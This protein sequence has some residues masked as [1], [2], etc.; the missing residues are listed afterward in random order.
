MTVIIAGERSGVGKTTI[1]LAI[2]AYLKSQNQSLQ[3]F[4]VGPDYID[5]MF[6]STITDKPCRNLD[7]I[8]TSQEYVKWCFDY[9]TQS[10]ELV[11]IEGV[12]GLF[13]GVPTDDSPYY[14]S[15]AYIAK[16][17]NLPVILIL[18]CSK[19]SMSVGAIALG[20]ITLDPNIQ[21]VGLILN[22]VGSKKHLTL[23]KA[24]LKNCGIPIIGVWFRQQE[25]KLPSRHLGLIPTEEIKEHQIIFQQLAQLAQENINW[26]LLF[27][28]LVH[29]SEKKVDYFFQPSQEYKLKIAIARDKSLNFYYQDNLDILEKF[30]VELVFFSPLEDDKLPNNIHGLYL[31]GGF[32]EIFAEKLA[33]NMQLKS[34][35][36]EAINNGLPTYAECGGMMYLSQ[37]IIDFQ[38][39]EWAMIGVLPNKATMSK[40]LTLGYRQAK[41]LVDNKF[42]KKDFK[43]SGHEFH[44]AINSHNSKTSI[45]SLKD[46]FTHTQLSSH[47]WQ[48]KNIYSSYLHLHFANIVSQI[49][50]FLLGCFERII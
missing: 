19:L 26:N 7:P 28:Y 17:L 41:I 25:I 36:K 11:V 5:P 13:D 3:S 46:Y 16:L 33:N 6:H 50:Q 23:L 27:P 18:D 40:K 20:Y 45:I 15:T 24:G 22:K 32:P 1:T 9:H 10:S 35:I 48:I 30:G 43:F 31:G 44:H 2:L 34:N 8:L 37:A 38:G 49:E 21:I 39:R 47:G 29:N 14:A 12:M 42:V 4:K